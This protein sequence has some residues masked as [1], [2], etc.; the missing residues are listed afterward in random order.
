MAINKT[1]LKWG[2]NYLGNHGQSLAQKSG[3]RKFAIN[4]ALQFAEDGYH[5]NL[6]NQRY[7]VGECEDRYAMSQAIIDTAERLLTSP[8]PIAPAYLKKL[9][10][11]MVKS[12][13]IEGGD[14]QTQQEFKALHGRR[15]PGFLVVSPTKSCN[16]RCK[17]CYADSGKAHEKLSWDVF[18]KIL[19]E[20]RDI[21]GNRFIVISGGEPFTYKDQGKDL[22]DMVAKH[23]DMFF[24]AYTNSLLI[25]DKTAARMAELGN[26]SPAISVE[27][28]REKTDDRRGE[29]VFD[30]IMETMERLR[31]HGVPFG[32]SLTAT[33]HNCEELFSDAFMDYLFFEQEAVYGW[34]FH[35]MP[36]GRSFTLDLMPTIQQRQWMWQ[37]SWEL[38][39][40]K[41][42]FLA[43]FWNHGTLVDGCLAGGR[44]SGGGYLYINWDGKVTPCVFVPYS[45]VN[46]N[47]V[48][49]QGK[50]IADAWEESFFE[51]I[52][53]WQAD[54][55]K[56]NGHRGNLLSP[57][58]IRDH[59]DVLRQIIAETEPDPEN[60]PA[61]DALLDKD[62]MQG[63]I[64]YGKS[65]QELTDSI[66]QKHYLREN[67]STRPHA[68]L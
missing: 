36:I 42:L 62:Y 56:G 67:D 8:H 45:P 37:R 26:F 41:K 34:V 47:D 29:G 1:F 63:M 14:V 20:A 60:E 10:D 31:N 49:Q 68:E 7:S 59:H 25:D 19:T 22:L 54:Y 6:D 48:Y 5:N 27:G 53:T 66:W 38:I 2:V 17:G 28:W 39:K 44:S 55:L 21:F 52:R 43:D 51:H 61:R 15:P 35:Y 32:I 23:D 13:V 12:I 9:A 11:I 64:E 40:N 18:D 65:Y 33:T 4:K 58:I 16:L 30:G 50:T 46:I 24:M 57:C 3:F